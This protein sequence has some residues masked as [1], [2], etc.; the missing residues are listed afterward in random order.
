M[1]SSEAPYKV[2][3]IANFMIGRAM[4]DGVRLTH[5]QLQ[6]LVYISHGI[7]LAITGKKLFGERIEAWHFGPVVP[8]LYHEFKRFGRS[9]IRKWSVDFDLES[10]TF[11]TP[12]VSDSDELA[13][14]A[15]NFTW[16]RYGRTRPF[17]LVKITHKDGTPWEQTRAL[18]ESE[19]DDSLIERHYEE[20]LDEW[21]RQ[22]AA[23]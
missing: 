5:V 16:K 9:P 2:G 10:G 19:I 12:I 13:L 22:A 21:A 6:K 1:I 3:A 4:R 14:G 18:G 15:L 17:E 20:L 23:R 8:A 11:E 7:H